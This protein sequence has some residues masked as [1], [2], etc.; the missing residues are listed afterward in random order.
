[1]NKII[2]SLACLAIAGSAVSCSGVKETTVLVSNS[3]NAPQI[4]PLKL[5]VDKG[6]IVLFDG[7]NLDGWRGYG[8]GR[9]G[10]LFHRLVFGALY[11][12]CGGVACGI[13][14]DMYPSSW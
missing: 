3:L 10:G 11:L 13:C 9:C 7:T 12:Y 1:M 14:P 2:Y 4:Q 8:F 6:Y 5:S